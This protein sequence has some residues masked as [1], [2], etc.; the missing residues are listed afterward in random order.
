MVQ[1]TLPATTHL[2]LQNAHTRRTTTYRKI[3]KTTKNRQTMAD[4]RLLQILHNMAHRNRRRPMHTMR[5]KRSN[6]RFN[7][8]TLN[9]FYLTR[10]KF[11][12]KRKMHIITPTLKQH[13]SRTPNHQTLKPQKTTTAKNAKTRR[14]AMHADANYDTQIAF[15]L[16]T[17]QRKP[18]KEFPQHH[19]TNKLNFFLSHR[20]KKLE[21]KTKCK[22]NQAHTTEMCKTKTNPKTSEK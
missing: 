16:P 4:R 11:R 3:H 8:K 10:K 19:P 22:T 7:L 9:F 21:E 18:Y 2:L 12:R 5:N 14:A 6:Q 17:K 1:K 13:T 20:R 15:A